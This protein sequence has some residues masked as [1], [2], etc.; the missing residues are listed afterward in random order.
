MPQFVGGFHNRYYYD[1]HYPFGPAASW[2]KITGFV[3]A[4]PA[5][6]TYVPGCSYCTDEA[7]DLAERVSAGYIM[8]TVDIG[9]FRLVAGVR[10]EGTQLSTLSYSD[11]T[12]SFP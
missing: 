9:R 8:N 3:A 11:D 7:F 4:N 2:D 5:A 12:Q 1:G 10:F 6:F